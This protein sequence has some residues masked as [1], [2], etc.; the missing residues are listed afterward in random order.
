[1]AT[2]YDGGGRL[3]AAVDWALRHGGANRDWLKDQG[4]GR[5]PPAV[6]GP[7]APMSTL[8]QEERDRALPYVEPSGPNA[9]TV[10]PPV[11]GV[12]TANAMQLLAPQ[13]ARPGTVAFQ[14]P[15]GGVIVVPEANVRGGGVY[16]PTEKGLIGQGQIPLGP[17]MAR[18]APVAPM[19]GMATRTPPAVMGEAPVAP[20]AGMAPT[21]PAAAAAPVAPVAGMAAR[22]PPTVLEQREAQNR[23]VDMQRARI[24]RGM[25]TGGS[26]SVRERRIAVEMGRENQMGAMSQ[27]ADRAAVRKRMQPQ[28]VA[29]AAG[30]AVWD[31]EKWVMRGN[32]EA[33][34]GAGGT[35]TIDAEGRVTQ[36]AAPV[37]VEPTPDVTERLKNLAP[38]FK[39]LTGT[40]VDPMVFMQ[41]NNMKEGP[42]K[43]AMM[44][45]LMSGADAQGKAA[46]MSVIGALL[47]QV[48]PGTAMPAAG[49]AAAPTGQ[50]GAASQIYPA[51][52]IDRFRRR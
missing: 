4:D 3:D 36:T 45:R 41:V 14:P 38:L 15:G 27:E 26:T 29:G 42:E 39:S 16:A 2:R 20:V 11:P 23:T 6:V 28:G 35:V 37:K 33:A 19:A 52:G 8:T 44:D 51:S 21:V 22:T 17:A 48:A 49:A 5:P 40:D 47:K 7:W 12:A 25:G 46:M 34:S 18:E 43:K 9:G 10:L 13:S 50:A 31:G 1:M 24:E 30:N 32:Q